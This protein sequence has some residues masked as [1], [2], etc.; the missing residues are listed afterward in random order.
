MEVAFIDRTMRE[1][2]REHWPIVWP[3]ALR[4]MIE[5]AEEGPIQT[6]MLGKQLH[7]DIQVGAH[8]KVHRR[9]MCWAIQTSETIR[10]SCKKIRPFTCGDLANKFSN[11]S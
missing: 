7:V 4:P 11:S 10:S 1:E 2:T 9:V 3:R 6:S 5:I 8:R